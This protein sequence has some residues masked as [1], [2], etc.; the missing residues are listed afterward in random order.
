MLGRSNEPPMFP[1]NILADFAAGGLLCAFGI[2]LALFERSFIHILAYLAHFSIFRTKSGKGQVIDNA[3]VDGVL[4]IGSFLYK[5]KLY[6]LNKPRIILI[7][8]LATEF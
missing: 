4:Y 2:V 5:H 3:M 1:I 6:V 7:A 8:L